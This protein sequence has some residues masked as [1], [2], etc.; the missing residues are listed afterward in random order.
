MVNARDLAGLGLR[1]IGYEEHH[2]A[3]AGGPVKPLRWH[4]GPYQLATN[5]SYLSRQ[6]ARGVLKWQL[7]VAS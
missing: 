1:G 2:A 5:G 3:L 7:L 4:H 6:T